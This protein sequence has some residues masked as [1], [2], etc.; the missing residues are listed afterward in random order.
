[1]IRFCSVFVLALAMQSAFSA[2][3]PDIRQ[4]MT[5]EEFTDS[6]LERLSENEIAA[7]NRWLIRYTAQDAEDI[8]ES[9]PAVQ[10]I[11]NAAIRSRID[12]QFNGWNGPTR[13]RLQNGE[14]WE[15][16]S[17]RRYDYSAMNPEVEITRNWMGIH[18]MR[19]LETGRAIN[20]RRVE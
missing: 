5:A 16:S 18:R 12:G 13:F 2:E 20:V 7:L 15:T 10:E 4:L 9:S 11:S 14:I 1:M 19:I 17:T 6:G 3:D 8:L